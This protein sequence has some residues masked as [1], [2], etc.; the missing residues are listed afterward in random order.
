[1]NNGEE[2]RISID[3]WDKLLKST[4]EKRKFFLTK[5]HRPLVSGLDISDLKILNPEIIRLVEGK[6]SDSWIQI[7]W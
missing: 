7:I 1:V 4:K 5:V 2:A 6:R 3:G